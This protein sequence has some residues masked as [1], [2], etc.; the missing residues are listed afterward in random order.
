MGGTQIP[1]Y[2]TLPEYVEHWARVT[3]EA[4]AFVDTGIAVSYRELRA[5]M[6]EFAAA[7]TCNGIGAGDRVAMLTNPRAEYWVCLLGSLR[8]GATWVG[9]NPRYQL[10]ELLHVVGDSR[11]AL[12]VGMPRSGERNLVPV[13]ERLAEHVSAAGP[14]I[15]KDAGLRGWDAFVA[16]GADAISPE[17]R[18]GLDPDTGAL[19]VY[20]SGSTGRPKGAV[21]S[22]RALC[23]SFRIQARHNAVESMRVVVNLPINHIGGVGDLC[24]TAL[25]QGGTLLFQ[26]QFNP[27]AIFD[28]IEGQGANTLMQ[29]P[30]MLKIL[31]S[32]PRWA[33]ADLSALQ[34]IGWGGGALPIDTIVAL[35]ASGARLGT[36]YG[37]TEI[38]GSVSYSQPSATDEALAT[39]VGHPI[40]QIDLRLI[41]EQDEPVGHGQEG[42]VAVRHPGMFVAYFGNPEATASAFTTDGYFRTGDVAVQLDNGALR[43]VGRRKE[44]YKSGG[45]NVYPR[46]IELVL[47]ECPGV[48]M[49]AVVPAPHELFGEVGVAFFEIDPAHPIDPDDLDRWC[50]ARLA[51]Y[52]IPK[53][54]HALEALPLLPIGKIDK[55]TLTRLAAPADGSPD[56]STEM[57]KTTLED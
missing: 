33:T 34:F 5:R 35:R 8:V 39:T 53:Q 41:N 20:T 22:N 46:E 42:E 40:E 27:E 6:D 24:C 36:T 9:L 7:L 2:D 52:K 4:V 3:P 18:Q 25:V 11:P 29:V 16:T 54:F 14:V 55:L 47:E 37:M 49:A 12:L 19:I 45:Y 23:A 48:A 51:N 13:L 32:S 26:E 30:S 44:M 56:T 10:D 15:L 43:L 21:L 57:P 50:R 1:E 31:T 28:A 17:P 38:T